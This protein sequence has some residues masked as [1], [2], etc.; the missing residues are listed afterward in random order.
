[1][2]RRLHGHSTAFSNAGS[3][4]ARIQREIFMIGEH[5]FQILL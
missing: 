5:L 2:R 1:M 3:E 4:G